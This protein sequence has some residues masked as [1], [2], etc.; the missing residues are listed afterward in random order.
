M[1]M[2]DSGS[3]ADRRW[4]QSGYRRWWERIGVTGHEADLLIALAAGLGKGRARE[5]MDSGREIQE[6]KMN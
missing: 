6:E 2:W 5:S 4:P 1:R 3:Q